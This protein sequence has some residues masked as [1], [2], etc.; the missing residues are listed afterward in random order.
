M[1]ISEWFKREDRSSIKS[2]DKRAVPEGIWSQCASCKSTIFQNELFAT[3]FVCPNCSHHYQLS[4]LQR[5]DLLI[6]KDTFNETAKDVSSKD[7]LK[8]EATKKYKESI[9][10]AKRSTGLKEAIITGKGSLYGRPVAIGIMDFR[11]IGGSMGSVVGEKIVRLINMAIDE[12]LPVVIVTASGGA[13]MQE[14][15]FS[16]MQ[17]AKTTAAIDRLQKENLPYVCILTNPTTGGVMA[18]FATLADIIIAEPK[19]LIGFTGPKVIEQTIKQKVPKEFQSSEKMLEHGQ[20][21]MVVE[22]KNLKS[23][24]GQV[25]D[26]LSPAEVVYEKIR[27]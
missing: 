18:S 21:D 8:F 3:D 24:I 6:D 13:R 12:S 22:R 23:T 14:G 2:K 1:S 26:F 4:A 16:L 9:D 11:F 25:L 7:P 10:K 19:A 27:S 5:I 17:M 15:I 20:I